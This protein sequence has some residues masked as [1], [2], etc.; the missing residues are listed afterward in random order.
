MKKVNYEDQWFKLL[1]FLDEEREHMIALI[2][3]K[4]GMS[5]YDTG[6]SAE[7][8]LIRGKMLEMTDERRRKHFAE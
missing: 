2:D 4:T 7:L 6:M 5:L 3:P 8:E 1:I